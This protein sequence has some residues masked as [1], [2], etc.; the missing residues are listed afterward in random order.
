MMTSFTGE[1]NCSKFLPVKLVVLIN[2]LTIW[3]DHYNIST[4][5]KSITLKVFITLPCLLLQKPSRNSKAKGHS[6]TLEDRLKLWN[7]GKN[8]YVS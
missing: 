1:K 4:P 6:K 7:E 8:R 2:E 5:F 3:L